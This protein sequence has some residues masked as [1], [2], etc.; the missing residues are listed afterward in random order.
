[1]LKES[2]SGVVEIF[3]TYLF[4][5][6]LIFCRVCDVKNRKKLKGCLEESWK[7]LC[8]LPFPLFFFLS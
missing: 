4:F 8:M 5:F 3:C 2:L 1:M 7:F 6:L